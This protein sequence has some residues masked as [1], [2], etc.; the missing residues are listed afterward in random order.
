MK[1]EDYIAAAPEGTVSITIVAN[2]T[3]GPPA[4]VITQFLED[5]DGQWG[6]T[7]D[8]LIV[9]AEN[10]PELIDQ[11]RNVYATKDIIWVDGPN[12]PTRKGRSSK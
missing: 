12:G 5:D 3:S 10:I 8:P 4:A 6:Q 9:P 1:P 11:L 2:S 7:I